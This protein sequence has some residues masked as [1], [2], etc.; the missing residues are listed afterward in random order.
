M[1]QKLILSLSIA[2]QLLIIISCLMLSVRF[3]L[4]VA[5]ILLLF[6]ALWYSVPDDGRPFSGGAS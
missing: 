4:C 1:K 2:G 6:N 5:G 3:G